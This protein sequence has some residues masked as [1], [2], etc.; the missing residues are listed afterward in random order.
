M[1]SA[2]QTALDT[3]LEDVNCEGFE[4][5]KVRNELVCS[6]DPRHNAHPRFPHTWKLPSQVFALTKQMI[7]S[8]PPGS[9]INKKRLLRR[10]NAV[11]LFVVH[12]TQP[13]DPSNPR[14][15][16]SK[17]QS[18]GGIRPAYWYLD[19]KRTG[20]LRK[21]Q[22]PKTLLGRKTKADVTIECG[23]LATKSSTR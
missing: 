15:K 22:P 12:P 6:A 7:E 16:P 19:L 9:T 1:R 21:G 10:V 8:P 4:S 11:L 13:L 17:I 2:A 23:E 18:G 20:T 14:T 5:S 3:S